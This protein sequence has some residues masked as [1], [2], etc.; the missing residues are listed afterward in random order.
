MDLGHFAQEIRS[1]YAVHRDELHREVNEI[2]SKD[3]H[4][5]VKRNAFSITDLPA[6]I[7]ALRHANTAGLDDRQLLL[8]KV[9][10]LMSRLEHSE[11]SL[12]I[13][14]LAITLLYKDLPHPATGYLALPSEPR[15]RALAEKPG[16]GQP[17]KYAFRS[18]D[19]SNYNPSS[20]SMGR[21]GSPYARS[22]PSANCA[23][24]S[25]LPDS[26]LVFDT[27][28][29]RQKFEPH[30]DGISSL[31]F[32]FA[33]LVIHSIFDTR[34]SDWTINDASSYLD[35]SILYGSSEV[36]VDGIRRKD[37]SG[38]IWDDAFAD[39]R[40]LFMPP[41]TCALL[42]IAQRILD[43]NERGN[44]HPLPPPDEKRIAQDDEIFHRARLVNCG[45]FMQI[46]LGD[47]VGAILGLVRDGCEWR[48]DP[49]MQMRDNGHELV[50][51]GEGNAV[52]V[53][54]N[55]LY[56]WHATLSEEDAKWTEDHFR[57]IF[58][59]K[60]PSK[61]S[62]RDFAKGVGERMAELDKDPKQWTFGDLSRGPD[63]RFKDDDLAKILQDATER[64]AGAFGAR[65]TPPV[66]RIIEIL[67]IEQARTWG[68]CSKA[69]QALYRDINNLEL[70]VGLQAEQT[71]SPGPGAGLSPGYTVSRAILADAVCLTRGDR[72]LTTDFTPYNLTAWGYQDCQYDKKDG[73]Y[74]GML[75]KLLF[76]TLPNHYPA[77][78]AYAHFPF[79]LP[80]RMK[81][82]IS[83]N[84]FIAKNVSKYGW[85]RPTAPKPTIKVDKY[86]A[87]KQVL[88]RPDDFMQ[89]YN[90]TLSELVEKSTGKDTKITL[91]K[92]RSTIH[93]I[94]LAQDDKWAE[95][96]A[97]EAAK[98]VKERSFPHT[99]QPTQ[100]LDVVKDVLNIIP[101]HWAS[102]ITGLSL[103][104]QL[105]TKGRYDEQEIYD[106][107]GDV[108]RYIFL[109]H[110]VV[111]HWRLKESTINAFTKVTDAIEAHVAPNLF[112]DK[113]SPLG[114]DFVKAVKNAGKGWSKEETAAYIFAEVIPTLPFFSQALAH[115]VNYF[116]D[117]DQKGA[118]EE[119]VKLT[120]SQDASA[121]AT[122]MAYY[123]EA[124]RLDPPVSVLYR[125]AAKDVD[126]PDLKVS[127][128]ERVIIDVAAANRDVTV[129]ETSAPSFKRPAEQ[130]GVIALL[131][132]G[133]LLSSSLFQTIA[134]QV[135][136]IVFSLPNLSRG[137]G[138][139]QEH[140]Q[141]IPIQRYINSRG[142]IV[143]W[144]DSLIIQYGPAAK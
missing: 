37:G 69:A 26:G 141:Q 61:I 88:S 82:H 91:A 119:I 16:N 98:L 105:Q 81:N 22:V 42:Y 31:F 12:K 135:L 50:P 9:L 121:N 73:S 138:Q 102:Q 128:S 62:I 57:G 86:A 84:P 125:A 21:A 60:E 44:F 6:Y 15:V 5:L 116:L 113:L 51:R 65:G 124:L 114:Q 2:R 140:W 66:L 136:K 85:T 32:A 129:F 112:A 130:A 58:K 38:K 132:A 14:Q 1:Y 122:L 36:Q 120:T 72:F 45:Y 139:F 39:P 115:I 104:T 123:R 64:P 118:R 46:I 33:D 83:G 34:H 56:R 47:Y 100:Y 13:Q 87:M 68:I 74:G 90:V 76:R 97:S 49:L 4:E 137:P 131:D 103:K 92:G 20:P 63:G 80:M 3:T 25:A 133:G 43:I 27:L 142:K 94:L 95:Y 11:I 77:G 30:P 24:A 107:F 23:P 78:S 93:D 67:G 41:A 10:V 55:M 53:E 127:A 29:R 106:L 48:L 110:D 52:S 101:V 111:D 126:L 7:D 35:L 99:G 134:P 59:G 70:Y 19:G 28:L 17:I 8:E 109:N 54:F 89:S 79:M 40:L 96:F 75:T 144:P 18:A 117:E 108:G 143:P 71:K